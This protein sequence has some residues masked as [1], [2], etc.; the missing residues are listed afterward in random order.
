MISDIE[1]AKQ[2][3]ER[4]RKLWREQQKA[5]MGERLPEK[6]LTGDLGTKPAPKTGVPPTKAEL[7]KGRGPGA[8]AARLRAARAKEFKAKKGAGELAGT[9][10]D[11]GAMAKAEEMKQTAQ[12]L[13]NIYRIVNGAA[14]MTLVG[15][16]LTFLVMNAQ[17]FFGNLLKVRLIP[18]LSLVEIIIILVLDFIVGSALL[19]IIV[20]ITILVTA[21]TDPW[22]LIKQFPGIAWEVFK[23]LFK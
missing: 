20:F 16:I 11:T 21:I 2:E 9:A 19:I 3:Q 12:R 17:L 14:G 23:S 4:K 6:A 7:P 1:K 10:P 22:G 5:R 18:A 8:I 15:L 13:K